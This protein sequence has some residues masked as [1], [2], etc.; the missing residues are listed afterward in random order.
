ME[1]EPSEEEKEQALLET[2]ETVVIGKGPVTRR[3]IG[4]L[5]SPPSLV[6]LR[7]KVRDRELV[8]KLFCYTNFGR[9]QE[10]VLHTSAF[11]NE[12]ARISCQRLFLIHSAAVARLNRNG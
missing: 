7:T 11:L 3:I 4:G 10:R 2:P 6:R 5:P 9:I 12:R 8:R 1:T